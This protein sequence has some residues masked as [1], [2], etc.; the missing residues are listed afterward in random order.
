[1]KSLAGDSIK[2]E[3]LKALWLQRLPPQVRAILAISSE[4]L[5]KLALLGDKILETLPGQQLAA[6]S[7]VSE[8]HPATVNLEI[9]ITALTKKFDELQRSVSQRKSNDQSRSRPRNRSR[10]NSRA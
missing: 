5:T 8:P 6:S 4:E 9:Q 2:D 7:V 10:S 3:A 1:M